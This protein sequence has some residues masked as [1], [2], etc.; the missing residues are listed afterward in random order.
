MRF[1]GFDHFSSTGFALSGARYPPQVLLPV[2]LAREV[3][4]NL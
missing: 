2:A 3:K 4:L 1:E